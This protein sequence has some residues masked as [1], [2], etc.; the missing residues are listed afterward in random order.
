LNIP[1]VA[2]RWGTMNAWK[3]ELDAVVGARHGGKVDHVLPALRDLDARHPHA[4]EIAFQLAYTLELSGAATEAV[5]HYE[6]ALALGLAEAEHLNALAGL[7]N[8]LRLAGQAARAVDLLARA[9]LQFPEARE[10]V[11]Y[12]ALALRDAGRQREAVQ[13]LMELALELGTDDLGLAAHQ[14]ALRHHAGR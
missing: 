7:G 10:L 6:R 9:A 12:R 11:A 1:G 13:V 2:A 4:A 8:A 3:N 5:P 14:R